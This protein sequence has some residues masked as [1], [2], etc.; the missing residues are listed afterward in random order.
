MTLEYLTPHHLWDEQTYAA[1]R[2]SIR[3]VMA[4]Y[5]T[6]RRVFVGPHVTLCFE[7]VWTIWYQIQEMLAVERGGEGQMR[8]ELEAYN[9]LIPQQGQSV[10][11]MMIEIPDSLQRAHVLKQYTHIEEHITLTVGPHLQV[12]AQPIDPEGRT[13]EDGKTSSVHFLRFNLSLSPVWDAGH[14][15]EIKLS[16]THP[17]YRHSMFLTPTQKKIFF[18]DLTL[19]FSLPCPFDPSYVLTLTTP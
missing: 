8:D 12:H 4:A 16:I 18:Q 13:R 11:T 1:R 19:G 3:T 15:G 5:R 9:T 17:E 6:E 2:A 7:N 14:E 10:A